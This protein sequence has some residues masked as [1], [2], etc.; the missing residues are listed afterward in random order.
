MN[1]DKVIERIRALA[2][3]TVEN[4]ATEAEA[5]AAAEKVGEMLAKYNLSMSEVEV[6]EDNYRRGRHPTGNRKRQHE[7]QF[8]ASAIAQFTDTKVWGEQDD[9]RGISFFGADHD[10]EVALYLI[11]LFQ[12]AMDHEWAQYQKTDNY[13]RSLTHGR[14]QRASFMRGMAHRLSE[15]L[16]VNKQQYRKDA[17]ATGRDLVPVKHQVVEQEF[18][19][20]FNLKLRSSKSSCRFDS[21]AYG[22]GHEAGDKVSI[23]PGVKKNNV[24][25][26]LR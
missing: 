22:A 24:S 13:R 11:D 15:R 16:R 19:K 9:G 20:Q 4:G 17:A 18:K 12:S 10:V 7:V 14:S 23:N 25:G 5:L 3:K 26:Y 6:R 21:R 1:R 2:A 8:T